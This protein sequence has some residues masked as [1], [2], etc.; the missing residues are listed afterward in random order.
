LW[1]DEA[2]PCWQAEIEK[3]EV[4]LF[5]AGRADG[6]QAVAGGD[7]FETGGLEAACEGFFPD[8]A[9]RILCRFI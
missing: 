6:G 3:D 7:D 2:V 4:G 8:L 1:D 9:A 5:F